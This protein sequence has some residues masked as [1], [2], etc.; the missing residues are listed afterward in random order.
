[1]NYFIFKG[2]N[3]NSIKGLI[4]QEL[5]QIVKAKKR[6]TKTEIEGLDG[7]ILE[8]LGYEA[9][10]KTIKIGITK[11]CDIDKLIN[12]LDGSG[13]LILSNEPTKY[14]N[15]EIVDSINFERLL[16]YKTATI[17][18]HTQPFKYLINEENLVEEIEEQTTVNIENKG[19]IDSKPIITIYGTGNIQI[20]LNNNKVFSVDMKDDEYITIDTIKE[21]A[22]KGVILKNRQ[23]IGDFNNIRLQPGQNTITWIGNLT[24]IEVEPKSRWI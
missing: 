10:D 6:F 9:Y 2:I 14:Y 5:P 24:K 19:Y 21:D 3:S 4:V 20:N 22:Y 8:E 13:Q 17:K 12:W 15:V 7:D 18:L 1:M 11:E 16:R 23:M